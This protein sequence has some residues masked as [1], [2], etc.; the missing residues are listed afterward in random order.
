MR[1]TSSL[2]PD[3]VETEVEGRRLTLSNL[4]KVLYPATGFTKAD[5]IDYYARIA[6][7]MLPHLRD[8][9]LTMRRFPNGVASGSFFE[10]NVPKGAPSWIRTVVVPSVRDGQGGGRRGSGTGS[11]THVV[12]DGLPTLV[13][14]ANLAAIELHVPLWRV[15]DGDGRPTF[16]DHVVFDLDPG[17]GTG[18]VECSRIATWLADRLEDAP[19]GP[20][21][22]KTSGS[23]G[24]QVYAELTERHDWAGVRDLALGIGRELA[25]Q[26]PDLVVTNMRKELREGRVLIDWSQNHP[27]KTT[28]AAYSLRARPE[29]TVSTPIAWD[30]V[31]RCASGGDPAALRFVTAEVLERVAREGDLFE[32]VS[33]G[34]TPRGGRSG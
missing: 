8:R 16:P 33:P 15:G 17:P 29:P 9:P 32:A 2:S 31:Q 7:V 12:C 6:P 10:K 20:P 1:G 21:A 3:R 14:A 30:E 22:V 27:V 28:V 34:R 24:L 5:V 18:V 26:S 25:E 19:V 11:V 23:K 13:W 4:D